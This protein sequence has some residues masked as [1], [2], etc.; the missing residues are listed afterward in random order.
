MMPSEMSLLYNKEKGDFWYLENRQQL[1]NIVFKLKRNMHVI[2]E[3]PSLLPLFLRRWTSTKRRWPGGRSASSPPTRTRPAHTRSSPQPIP[4]GLC[5][6]S[7]SP[8][9]TA[10]WTTWA[11]ESRWSFGS[12]PLHFIIT[13]GL[14]MRMERL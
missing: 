10:C 6:T 11:T 12:S 8:S 4:R 14:L 2:K 3:T 7:A 1:V 9:T 13:L 5:A